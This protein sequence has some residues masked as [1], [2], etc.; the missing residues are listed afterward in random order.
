VAVA[1]LDAVPG[2]P[3]R[4]LARIEAVLR[5]L[6]PRVDLVVFPELYLTGYNLGLRLGSLAEPLDG[7]MLGCLA[8]MARR[9]ETALIVGFPERAGRSLYNSAAVVDER[10][11]L[12]G[13]YRKIHLFDQERETF[14]AGQDPLVVRL[15]SVPVGVCICY[16]LEFPEMARMLALEG[17]QLIAVSTA[18]MRPWEEHQD[19]YCRSRAME[20][21][22]FVA[23]ANRVGTEGSVEFFGRSVIVG[24]MGEKLAQAPD[25]QEAVVAAT[26]RMADVGEARKGAVSYLRDRRPD[27]YGRLA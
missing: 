6:E 20:N 14:T 10:G 15:K 26:L 3:E 27:R 7:A 21:Q 9:H 17:A 25:G 4:N 11:R 12:A 22:V 13:V 16:D 24:P 5:D 2:S 18:N 23:V 1:Q 19:V 8:D